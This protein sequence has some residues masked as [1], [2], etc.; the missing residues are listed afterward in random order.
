MVIESIVRDSSASNEIRRRLERVHFPDTGLP[1]RETTL[2]EAGTLF[3]AIDVGSPSK[4][5]NY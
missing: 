4:K 5:L 1:A 3:V 2:V